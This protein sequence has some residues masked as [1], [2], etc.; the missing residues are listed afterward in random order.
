MGESKARAI[1]LNTPYLFWIYDFYKDIFVRYA[2]F[3][4]FWRRK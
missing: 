1:L 2:S 3:D 4:W